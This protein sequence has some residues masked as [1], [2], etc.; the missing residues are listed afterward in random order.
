MHGPALCGKG[1]TD[2]GHPAPELG[3]HRIEFQPQMPTQGAV[4]LLENDTG[5]QTSQP[6][7]RP[8]HRGLDSVAILA[9]TVPC[10][11]VICQHIACIQ[12]KTLH[13]VLELKPHARVISASGK[14]GQRVCRACEIV[15]YDSDFHF[16]VFRVYF[17][18][19]HSQCVGAHF[20]GERRERCRSWEY[21][22]LLGRSQCHLPCRRAVSTLCR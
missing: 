13:A 10:V 5:P 17:R 14:W 12:Q 7:R 21:R 18:R 19:Q 20:R 9:S 8:P 22:R 15:R 3:P 6:S 4:Y 11:C 2:Q 1:R 16:G